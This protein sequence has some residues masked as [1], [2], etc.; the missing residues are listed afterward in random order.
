MRNHAKHRPRPRA[1]LAHSIIKAF[2]PVGTPVARLDAPVVRLIVLYA[3]TVCWL[4][5]D[6]SWALHGKHSCTD[7]GPAALSKGMTSVGASACQ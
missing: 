2:E 5:S 3:P 7:Q 6:V 1:H 4:D